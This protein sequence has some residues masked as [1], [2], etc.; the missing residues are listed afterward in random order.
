[1][2]PAFLVFAIFAISSVAP[3]SAAVAKPVHGKGAASTRPMTDVANDPSK[4]R[5]DQDARNP[6]IHWTPELRTPAPHHQRPA[7]D[8]FKDMLLG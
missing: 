5:F 7:D 4:N 6:G 2:R 3:N 8:P 1:M